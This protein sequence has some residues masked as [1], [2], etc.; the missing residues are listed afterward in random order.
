MVAPPKNLRSR[1]ALANLATT[2]CSL[3]HVKRV[4]QMKRIA[5]A[6]VVDA[7]LNVEDEDYETA[8]ILYTQA[9]H[10]L[11]DVI[12]QLSDYQACIQVPEIASYFRRVSFAR[13]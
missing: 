9:L 4:A 7:N 13:C 10:V 2:Q 3:M 5:E 6:F 8:Y 12:P 11:E 1:S